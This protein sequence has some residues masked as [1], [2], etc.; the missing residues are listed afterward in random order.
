[1]FNELSIKL[2]SH[3]D[4]FICS[5][6]DNKK[7]QKGVEFTH[8][9]ESGLEEKELNKLKAEFGH[10]PSLIDFY[11]T[12]SSLLL[13]FDPSSQDSAFYFAKPS[14]WVELKEY[15]TPWTPLVPKLLLG[16]ADAL[17]AHLIKTKNLCI[18]KRS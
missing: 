10:I 15:L 14:E 18:P 4:K 6:I 2:R 13:Y 17:N 3:S 16:N 11:D 7:E 9:T 8:L 5:M 12:W 1:M